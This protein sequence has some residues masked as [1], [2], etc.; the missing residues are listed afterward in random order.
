[1]VSACMQGFGARDRAD[2]VEHLW[3]K[4]GEGAVVSACMQGF[5][6]RDRADRDERRGE[7]LVMRAH[8]EHI[9]HKETILVPDEGRNQRP[10]SGT[11]ASRSPM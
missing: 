6:A 5:G 8:E 1:M 11:Q 9:S 3:G 2:R 4:R 10:L 7:H